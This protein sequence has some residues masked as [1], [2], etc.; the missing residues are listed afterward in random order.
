MKS[1]NL[2][3]VGSFDVENFGDLLFPVVFEFEIKKRL[4]LNNLYLF[5]P[6]GGTM[7][8]Y[9]KRVH[10]TSNLDEFCFKHDI[11]GI[12]IG[13][14]DTIRLDRKVLKDY[15]ESFRPSFS[16][17]QYPLLVAD[18]HNLPAIFNCPGSPIDFGPYR[19][20][21]D[22]TLKLSPYISV[23][24]PNANKVLSSS[25]SPK[26][27]TVIDSVNLIDEVYP[28]SSL[29]NLFSKLKKTHKI[30]DK[31]II[32]QVNNIQAD[33]NVFIKSLRS[34][35]ST[36]NREYDTQVIFSP[37]GYVHND[38]NCLRKIY[39]GTSS[40]NIIIEEKMN[41][42]TMLALF[43]YSSGF[44][45]TS[46]HGLVTSNVYHVPILALD[47]QARNKIEGYMNLCHLENRIIKDITEA[48]SIFKKVF[49]QPTDYSYFDNE[50]KKLSNH[51]DTIAKIITQRKTNNHPDSLINI[52]N[53]LYELS[54]FDTKAVL[55]NFSTATGII[56]RFTPQDQQNY[57]LCPP[58]DANKLDI[59]FPHHSPIIIHHIA[60]TDSNHQNIPFQVSN[61]LTKN[62]D[63]SVYL[64][65][66][67]TANI[68]HPSDLKL[69]LDFDY[70]PAYNIVQL[71]EQYHSLG[72]SPSDI[73]RI[74]KRRENTIGSKIRKL[75][76]IL[77][78]SKKS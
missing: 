16:M 54:F 2:I 64:D 5:S 55:A 11:D 72:Y 35:V 20:I 67:I 48:S 53:N 70:Y 56:T 8:F 7:P 38:L 9:N 47:T 41:P 44:I 6:N 58:P 30:E 4:K 74:I 66:I 73:Q 18:K 51:F 32:L 3:Q 25:N 43:S 52:L 12:I 29:A 78:K 50:R 77:S 62:P 42:E 1:Y 14:G 33:D 63:G 75:K 45:G 40:R 65:P 34:L 61:F 17:W 76:K 39:K 57:S 13:G 27:H 60:L 15:P 22:E 26:V 46:L 69:T 36:I 71:Y 23:R 28:K 19:S 21:V 59:T 49:F 31:Y 10:S 24:D 37:I 68:E